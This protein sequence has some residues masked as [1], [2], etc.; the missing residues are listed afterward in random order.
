MGEDADA[1]GGKAAMSLSKKDK[2][3][4]LAPDRSCGTCTLCCKVFHIP[5]LDKP[6]GAWCRN[7][8]Q[9]AG[10]GIHA[11]R[12]SQCRDF[13]CLWLMDGSMPAEWKPERSKM[14]LSLFPANGFIYAQV[15]PGSPQAWRKAPYY[16]A[17]RRWA[18]EL[19]ERGRHVIVFV[20]D[21]ATLIMPEEAV[22]LGKMAATDNFKIERAFGPNGPTY[23]VARS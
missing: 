21:H 22:P 11:T 20:N 1:T 23:R 13:F 3:P 15:D 2:A 9:G 19:I 12:P 6:A 14:V 16:D 4:F 17:L 5:E 8:V 7:C 18:K 10:C